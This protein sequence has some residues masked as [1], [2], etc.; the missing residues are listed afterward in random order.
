[1]KTTIGFEVEFKLPE[2]KLI[3]YSKLYKDPQKDNYGFDH[4]NL[5]IA[6]YR[7]NVF[8]SKLE[9]LKDYEAFKQIIKDYSPIFIHKSDKLTY[10][11]HISFGSYCRIK[12]LWLY[13]TIFL[14]NH[15]IICIE[16]LFKIRAFRKHPERL[17][18]RLI[19][20]LS[21]DKLFLKFINK[22]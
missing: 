22:L 7:S 19:P 15:P 2:N 13:I 8:K 18:F 6:E 21:N 16:R 4:F 5:D 12:L 20:T 10:G 9:L 3:D 14:I 1:M 17:E 11:I